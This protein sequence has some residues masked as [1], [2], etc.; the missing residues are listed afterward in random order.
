MINRNA[1]QAHEERTLLELRKKMGCVM[2]SVRGEQI[3]SASPLEPSAFNAVEF[4]KDSARIAEENFDAQPRKA[5]SEIES[6]AAYQ[7]RK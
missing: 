6:H 1:A 5:G 4:P 3:R 2:I 7:L